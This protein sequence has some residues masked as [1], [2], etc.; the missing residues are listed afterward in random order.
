M[1]WLERRLLDQEG[2]LV[3]THFWTKNLDD[4]ITDDAVIKVQLFETLDINALYWYLW[5]AVGASV[6]FAIA[7]GVVTKDHDWSTAFSGASWVG[8]A[9]AFVAAILGT[10]TWLGGVDVEV[11]G[12]ELEDDEDDVQ[13]LILETEEKILKKMDERTPDVRH[14]WFSGPPPRHI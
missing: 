10:K 5:V 9:V 8:T 14:G 7:Y 1:A 4:M 6:A 2:S 3:H 11:D 13:D 12:L